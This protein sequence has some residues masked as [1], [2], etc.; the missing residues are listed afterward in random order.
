MRPIAFPINGD[1]IQAT[2]SR[3]LRLTYPVEVIGPIAI[4]PRLCCL[5]VKILYIPGV[6]KIP[7]IINCLASLHASPGNPENELQGNISHECL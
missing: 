7:R 5:P 3:A 4:I 6:Q 2:C 1:C